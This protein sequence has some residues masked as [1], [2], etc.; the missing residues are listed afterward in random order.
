MKK[1][2]IIGI[3]SNER[4]DTLGDRFN[5][6][7]ITYSGVDYVNSVAYAGGTPTILPLHEDE[8][9]I[10]SYLDMI[11]GLVVTGG[12][13]VH[14]MFYGEDMREGCGNPYPRRDRFD[15]MLVKKAVERKIPVLA[16][17]RGFQITNVVFGGTLYQDLS[18]IKN[19]SLKH[20]Q[21]NEAGVASH[22]IQILDPE[23]R[24]AQ[25]IGETKEQYINS[26]H[27]QALN[28]VADNFHV[29]ATAADGVVEVMELPEED[30]FYIAVQYH[31]EMMT[32]RGNKQTL[33]LFEGLVEAAQS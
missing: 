4:S 7:F 23:S 5:D 9:I 19:S 31:P 17:C 11:D 16:I 15:M 27:H 32:N 8:A 13:D 14:P 26:F 30:Y 28:K 18:E 24:Y 22:K 1:K 2:P 25:L 20:D 12:M 6:Y 21:V 33:R 29:V 10:D 3:S